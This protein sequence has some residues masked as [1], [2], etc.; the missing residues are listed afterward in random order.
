[1]KQNEIA[2]GDFALEYGHR[3]NQISNLRTEFKRSSSG[4]NI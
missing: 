3:G 4:S 2:N 1:M